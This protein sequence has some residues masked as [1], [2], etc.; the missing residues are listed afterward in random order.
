MKSQEDYE[1]PNGTVFEGKRYKS[2]FIG[3]GY[4]L[5][6]AGKLALV[7]DSKRDSLYVDMRGVANYGHETHCNTPRPL[8]KIEKYSHIGECTCRLCDKGHSGKVKHVL[9]F[10][11]ESMPE[12]LEF[13]ENAVNECRDLGYH[14]EVLDGS[15]DTTDLENE[16]LEL[17]RRVQAY[18]K[19]EYDACRMLANALGYDDPDDNPTPGDQTLTLLV[20]EAACALKKKT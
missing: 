12:R 7:N 6:Y 3:L 14:V 1:H 17:N 2:V 9:V 13:C 19:S 5:V 18:A 16:N 20:A 4:R 10:K 8:L 15:E 11:P